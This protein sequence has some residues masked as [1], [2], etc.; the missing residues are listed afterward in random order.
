MELLTNRVSVDETN[1]EDEWNDMLAENEWVQGQIDW[2]QG[3]DAKE[4][5]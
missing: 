1:I 3:P 4:W 5:E 2:D